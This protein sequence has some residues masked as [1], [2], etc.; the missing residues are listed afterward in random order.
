M[1]SSCMRRDAVVFP[2]VHLEGQYP[3]SDSRLT[4][5]MSLEFSWLPP[6]LHIKQRS[7]WLSLNMTIWPHQ[8]LR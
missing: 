3:F 6:A 7:T 8:A 5:Q 1:Q 4:S 2:S